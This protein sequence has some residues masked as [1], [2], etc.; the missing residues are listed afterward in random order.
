MKIPPKSQLGG[1]VTHVGFEPSE[2]DPVNETYAIIKVLVRRTKNTESNETKE[3]R[4]MALKE[5]IMGKPVQ[6][7]IN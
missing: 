3:A 2:T 7:F 1:V 6:L 5:Q 4:V